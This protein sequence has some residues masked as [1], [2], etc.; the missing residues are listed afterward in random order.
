MSVPTFALILLAYVAL[1]AAVVSAS[2]LNAWALPIHPS[3]SAAV[4]V[5]LS[6]LGAAVYLTARV[7]FRSFRMTWGLEN[8]TLITSGIYRFVRHPQNLGW[9]LLLVG[10]AL[11]GHSGVALAFAGL[12]V[13]TSIIWLP[14]EEKALEGQFGATYRRYRART[15]AFIPFMRRASHER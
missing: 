3:R 4:G 7:E 5:T 1:A 12:Y 10:V 9:A 15:P 14:V 8:Q 11:I 13:L 6:V 2:L